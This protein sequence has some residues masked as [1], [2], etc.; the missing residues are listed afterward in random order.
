MLKRQHIGLSIHHETV[1]N[2]SV[3]RLVLGIYI[4]INYL[5]V[6]TGCKSKQHTAPFTEVCAPCLL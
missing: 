2:R 5:N 6:R 1:R 3:M 4:L